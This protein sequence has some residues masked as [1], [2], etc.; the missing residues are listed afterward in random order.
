MWRWTKKRIIKRQI[1]EVTNQTFSK[2]KFKDFDKIAFTKDMDEI[3]NSIVWQVPPD[4]SLNSNLIPASLLLF[5][6]VV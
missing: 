6:L 3:V 2:Y 1:V 4:M 5:F